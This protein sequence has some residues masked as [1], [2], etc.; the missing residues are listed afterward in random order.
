MINE[1]RLTGLM[2]AICLALIFGLMW[3]GD[4]TP[5]AFAL[6]SLGA[7]AMVA[8]CVVSEL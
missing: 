1:K 5:G 2:S 7:A 6:L 8:V 3:L 4:A